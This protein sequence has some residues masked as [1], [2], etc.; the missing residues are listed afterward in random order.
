MQHLDL[1]VGCVSVVFGLA[2]IT[3]AAVDGPWL[4][5]LAKARLLVGAIGKTPARIV[6]ATLGAC[7]MAIGTLIASGWRMRW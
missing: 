2:L 6:M 5:S 4:M 1:L 3:G 7:L